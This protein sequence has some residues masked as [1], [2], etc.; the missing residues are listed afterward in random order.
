MPVDRETGRKPE[1]F[2]PLRDL[3]AS[4]LALGVID[5]EGDEARTRELAEA[6]ARGAAAWSSPSRPS[7]AWP[8]STSGVTDGPTLERLLELHAARRGA[9][10]LTA[11]RTA[12]HV[13]IALARVRI[14][15]ST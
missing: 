6:A 5:Y 13:R 15:V 2:E 4:R 1:Y 7:A 9:D 11:L 14:G 3:N 8:A 12:R 10:P